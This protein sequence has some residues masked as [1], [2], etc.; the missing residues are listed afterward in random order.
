MVDQEWLDTCV[1]AGEFLY[2]IFPAD[3]LQRMYASKAGHQAATQE[4]L[5]AVRNSDSILMHLEEGTLPDP[6]GT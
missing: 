4:L 3:L 1:Q 2:G 5:E 6:S